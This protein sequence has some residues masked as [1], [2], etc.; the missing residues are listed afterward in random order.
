M[1][2]LEYTHNGTTLEAY[3]AHHRRGPEKKPA[4]I[5][6]HAWRGRDAFVCEQAEYFAKL[7]YVGIA[8]DM[9]GK[10]VLGQTDEENA[11]LMQPFMDDRELLLARA[12]RGYE[13]VQ[14]LEGV[15]PRKIVA[16]GFCFGG[17][18]ALDLARNI[19]ELAGAISVHGL[20]GPPPK[21]ELTQIAAPILVYHG[22]EDPFVPQEQVVQ[23]TQEMTRAQADWQLHVFSQTYHAFTYPGAN[24]PEKGLLY[25]ARSAKRT[26]KMI[27]LFLQECFAKSAPQ[28]G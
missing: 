9:Y 6:L 13:T 12:R 14:K 20:L 8:L 19:T 16:M 24:T 27:E 23:F 11:Q 5:L 3:V 4:V 21:T 15:D 22:Y 10:G 18:C 26:F 28:E 25:K 2:L 1:H 7:G 17:L